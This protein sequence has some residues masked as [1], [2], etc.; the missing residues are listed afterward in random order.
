MSHAE[1]KVMGRQE[2]RGLGASRDEADPLIH[3]AEVL[4]ET[5]RVEGGCTVRWTDNSGAWH[6]CGSTREHWR[7]GEREDD[8]EAGGRPP[9]ATSVHDLL[10]AYLEFWR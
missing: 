3:L 2:D 9:H 4:L 1:H 10:H 7:Q 6:R 5:K 8:N